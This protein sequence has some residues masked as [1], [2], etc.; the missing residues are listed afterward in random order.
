MAES[1]AWA[2]DGDGGRW[3]SAAKGKY[4]KNKM[5]PP[6]REVTTQRRLC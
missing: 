2:V 5:F 1:E 6:G 3:N 4:T